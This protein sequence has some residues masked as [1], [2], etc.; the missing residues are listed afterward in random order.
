MSAKDGLVMFVSTEKCL[1]YCIAFI[2]PAFIHLSILLVC[3][4]DER[5]VGTSKEFVLAVFFSF[6]QWK[7]SR[8]NE[9][10]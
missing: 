1:D 3:L 8:I 4:E 7:T 9:N 10:T 5:A 6:S 2:Q